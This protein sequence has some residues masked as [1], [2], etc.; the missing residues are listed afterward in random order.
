MRPLVGLCRAFSDYKMLCLRVTTVPRLGV[1]DAARV[2]AA[3]VK[4]AGMG[5]AVS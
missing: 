1:K 5:K 4:I 2:E 3:F